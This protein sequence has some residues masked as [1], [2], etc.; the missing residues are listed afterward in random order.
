MTQQTRIDDE[1][2]FNLLMNPPKALKCRVIVMALHSI[3]HPAVSL[4]MFPETRGDVKSMMRN[5]LKSID[6]LYEK[7]LA[8]LANAA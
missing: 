8:V 3:S 4:E 2:R 5:T 1:K 7:A 6:P